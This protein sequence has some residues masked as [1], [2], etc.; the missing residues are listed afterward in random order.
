[1]EILEKT[2]QLLFR[3]KVQKSSI[4]MPENELNLKLSKNLSPKIVYFKQSY[5]PKYGGYE[6]NCKKYIIV[7]YN[8]IY[9]GEIY[10][11]LK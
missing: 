11:A 8:F 7:P 3:S 5:L 9:S 2:L 1:M 4:K 10:D 6:Y